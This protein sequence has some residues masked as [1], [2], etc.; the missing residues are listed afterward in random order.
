MNA[1]R[2]HPILLYGG[3]G[4]LAVLII[5]V[6][7]LTLLDWDMFRPAIARIASAKSG[8]TVTLPGHLRVHLW[9]STPTITLEGLRVA[10]PAW[11]EPRP[12]LQLQR[13]QIQLELGPL[14]RGHLILKRIEVDQPELYLHQEKSGRANWTN[15][16]VA[17]TNPNA[18]P[19]KPFSLPAIHELLIQSGKIDLDDDLRRLK[20][21]GTIQADERASTNQPDAFHIKGQGTINQE[22]FAL[23]VTGG[24][25]LSVG[26][27]HPYPFALSITAGNNQIDAS[28]KVLKPFDLGQ[29]QLQ[30]AVKGK[31]LAELF[32]LTQLALPNTPPFSVQ[33]TIGRDGEHFTVHDIK[34][35]LGS[36]DIGGNIDVDNSHP[37]P[38]LNATLESRHLLLSDLGALTGSKATA[39]DTLDKGGASAGTQ[40]ARK[41]KKSEHAPPAPVAH[42]FPDARLQ[43]D[44]VR[45]MD[46]DVHFKATSIEAGKVPFK[47]V[48]L[49]AKLSGGVLTL[50]P[51]QFEMP[52]GRLSGNI[53]IDA[54]QQ[55]PQVRM[56]VRAVNINLDQLKSAKLGPNAPVDGVMQARAVIQGK[57]DSVHRLMADANGSFVVVIPHGDIRSAFPELLGIDL[58]GVGL[59]LTGDNAHAPIRCGLAKFDISDGDAKAETILIDT[60]NVVIKGHGTVNLGTEALDLTISGDPKK[61]HLVRIRAPIDIRG[62]LLKPSFAPDAGKLAKQGAI[63]AALG[64]ALTPFAA[65]LAFVDPGLAKDQNCSALLSENSGPGAAPSKSGKPEK[66]P[67]APD[68]EKPR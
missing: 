52:E 38:I 57:G 45:A 9:S 30:A 28:G 55:I 35:T 27:D 60:Q 68:H 29:L 3:L 64:A 17:P 4:V 44:R 63:A 24:A 46:A 39:S 6:L 1:R 65:I 14:F 56:D 26:P 67:P 7:V 23:N 42:L 25:L 8:R 58:K 54:R 51:V 11:D 21:N 22:P 10:D 48:L 12:L 13:L 61:F 47:E 36:S 34:G 15:A 32:Y 66:Q 37:K 40:P 53:N 2:R 49:H 41:S 33:A 5:I 16:N 20:V 19:P 31:D 62:H 43:T 18:P 50:D 59:L